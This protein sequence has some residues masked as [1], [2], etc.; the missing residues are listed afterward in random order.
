[1]SAYDFKRANELR[2]S[3]HTPVGER[4]AKTEHLPKDKPASETP[5]TYELV[6]RA[7]ENALY[8]ESSWVRG[9]GWASIFACGLLALIGLFGLSTDLFLKILMKEITTGKTSGALVTILLLLVVFVAL[10]ATTTATIR[11]F[12]IDLF[13]PKDVPLV[14]NR[15]TRKVYK[16]I[17]N[18]PTRD[19]S[20]PKAI[21]KYWRTVFQP[22]P[23][24]LIE[25][26]W[27]CV[28]A[29]YFEQTSLQGNVVQTINILQLIVKEN[30]TS[31]TVIGTISLASPLM[32]GRAMAMNLWEHIR[33]YMEAGGPVLNP[34]DQPAPPYPTNLL[35]AAN[36]MTKGGWILAAIACWW[37]L[38]QVYERGILPAYQAGKSI[39]AFDLMNFFF[40]TFPEQH[41]FASL[42]MGFCLFFAYPVLL[43]VIFNWLAFKWGK[44]V[45]LPAELQA[46]AGA[47]L[48][49][50]RLAAIANGEFVPEPEP[51]ASAPASFKGS[52]R[53]SGKHR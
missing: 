30:P 3:G 52:S 19:F 10:I 48:D 35:Q 2:E 15:K 13:G 43:A 18:M 39:S 17:Q 27:D 36:T 11:A 41:Q 45:D 25:Y 42:T 26:D 28:E 4:A 47:P 20:S 22:W 31:D 21:V 51:A 40:G 6:R 9:R 44:D 46:D 14:F 32:V 38:K 23:M 7:S 5:K 33:R 53:K 16:F 12:R 8:F 24:L 49:L 29:E 34:G 37:S 50:K 1:M